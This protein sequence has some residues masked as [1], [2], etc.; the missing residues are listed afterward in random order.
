M[1]KTILITGAS[2]GIG[3]AIATRFAKDGYSLVITCS[4]SEQALLTLKN[5]LED[6][7]HVP[8]LA[9]LGDVGDYNY[10]TSL[11]E[12]I[13]EHFGG[14]DNFKRQ[15]ARDEFVKTYCNLNKIKFIE[16]KYD[17]SNT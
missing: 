11:F 3:A 5:E 17:V 13:R 2:R 7:Y 16:I 14:I 10:I 8:V 6:T 9:S 1:S 4:K 15:Q 12:S